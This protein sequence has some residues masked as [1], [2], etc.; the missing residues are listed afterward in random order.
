MNYLAHILLS[1]ENPLHLVGNFIGDSV[2]GN[3]YL[4]YDDGILTGI[5]LHRQIDSFMDSHPIVTQGMKRLY[6]NQRKFAGVVIDIFYDYFL[7]KNWSTYSDIDYSRFVNNTY[8]T[9][10][11]HVELMPTMSQF[12]LGKMISSDWLG[13]YPKIDGINRALIGLSKRTKYDN[14]MAN[15]VQDLIKY[16]EEF[17]AEFNSYFPQIIDHCSSYILKNGKT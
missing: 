4:E 11:K 2:K 10:E 7:C 14:N 3:D 12:I 15:A 6:P 8:A 5:L 17:N 16:E 13:H 9:L 1:G